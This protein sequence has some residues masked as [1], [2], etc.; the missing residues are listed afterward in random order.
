MGKASKDKRDIFYR[1]AKEE[2][3]RA[4][5]GYKLLQLL[6]EVPLL[7]G[8][9][10][11]VDLCGAPGS[12]SQ[13][14]AD[15][16]SNNSEA[17]IVTVD[18]QET[19]PIPGVHT[20]QGDITRD[21]TAREILDYFEGVPADLVICDGA[22]DVTGLHELDEY[23]QH[24]LLLSAAEITARLLKPGGD[25]VAKIFRG[26]ST[27]LVISKL[28]VLFRQVSV[29]KPRASRTSS[30]EAF[31]VAR[32]FS[33]APEYLPFLLSKTDTK[34]YTTTPLPYVPFLQCGDL[35]GYDAEVSYPTAEEAVSL[36]PIHPP[37]PLKSEA[38]GGS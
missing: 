33:P 31:V 2:G 10:R 25:F 32:G 6:E 12:W 19:A 20:I 13:V 29:M 28:R 17:L 15:R 7:D 4:R 18:L 37:I 38:E 1:K 27:P 8:V 24:E 3:Y 23:L 26:K 14:L 11:A 34:V 9:A 21:S 22:P 36:D 16:L 5:S 35:S 30:M